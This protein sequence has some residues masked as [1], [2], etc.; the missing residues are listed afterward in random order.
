MQYFYF[1]EFIIYVLY[2]N[3]PVS[4]IVRLPHPRIGDSHGQET[5]LAPTADKQTRSYDTEC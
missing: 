2:T 5:F 3:L 4:D 1:T